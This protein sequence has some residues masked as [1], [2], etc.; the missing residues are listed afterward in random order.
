MTLGK[1]GERNKI[2][3][4]KQNPPK[5]GFCVAIFS[6]WCK[7]P[8]DVHPL[9]RMEDKTMGAS[10]KEPTP[11]VSASDDARASSMILFTKGIILIVIILS[12]TKLL[13][14]WPR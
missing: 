6:R 4:D 12:T 7:V 10:T 3:N 2:E 11:G 1:T 13:F 14:D 5:G 9:T 8:L